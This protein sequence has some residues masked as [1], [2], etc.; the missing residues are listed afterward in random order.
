MSKADIE[1]KGA[2][3]DGH[4]LIN[5]HDVTHQT[6]S[7]T[8]KSAVGEVTQVTLDLVVLDSTRIQSDHTEVFIPADTAELLVKAGWTPPDAGNP[9][10]L[11]IPEAP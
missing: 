10:R 11:N 5:G 2:G 3:Y 8:I 4:I 1:I 6:R 9:A 7:V